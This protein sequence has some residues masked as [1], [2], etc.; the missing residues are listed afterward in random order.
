MVEVVAKVGVSAVGK[1]WAD[2]QWSD[3][4]RSASFKIVNINFSKNDLKQV[5]RQQGQDLFQ[6][7]KLKD[8]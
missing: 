4:R 6:T 2:N 3:K 1:I 7:K 8:P 5:L